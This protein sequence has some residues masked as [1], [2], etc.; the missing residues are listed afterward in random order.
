MAVI[1]NT[2]HNSH[3][4]FLYSFSL[5]R[6]LS[7]SH[8]F[9]RL[10]RSIFSWYTCALFQ[11]KMVFCRHRCCCFSMKQ[12]SCLHMFK[13]KCAFRTSS[14]RNKFISMA[15]VKLRSK[16]FSSILRVLTGNVVDQLHRHSALNVC[17]LE[18]FRRF[19][20]CKYRTLCTIER[21][22]SLKNNL[23]KCNTITM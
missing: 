7:I 8:S 19:E 18:I 16:M 10:V 21:R 13:F 23:F 11:P 9:C 5:S 2:K 22:I 4:F 17:M 15:G 12:Q 20:I 6:F 14:G 3:I 1:N